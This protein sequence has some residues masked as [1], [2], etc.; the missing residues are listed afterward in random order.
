ME[1]LRNQWPAVNEFIN[2]ESA[3]VIVGCFPQQWTIRTETARGERLVNRP[4]A[5]LYGLRPMPVLLLQL[6]DRLFSRFV[7]EYTSPY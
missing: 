6:R 7:S 4:A 3:G 2:N 1:T 5:P